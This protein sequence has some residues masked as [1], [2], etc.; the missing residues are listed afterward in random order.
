ML[1][2]KE[3]VR[4]YYTHLNKDLVRWN[5]YFK[6]TQK[7]RE[8]LFVLWSDVWHEGQ[9]LEQQLEKLERKILNVEIKR[10]R[11]HF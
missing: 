1:E 2:N 7:T 4:H 5:D 3:V 10:T 11:N 8:H 9:Q 6:S